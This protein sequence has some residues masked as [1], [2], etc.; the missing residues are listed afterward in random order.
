MRGGGFIQSA[1]SVK[2]FL[3]LYVSNYQIQVLL[4]FTNSLFSFLVRAQRF[5]GQKYSFWMNQNLDLNGI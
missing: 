3:K 5:H 1:R 4:Q 2:T